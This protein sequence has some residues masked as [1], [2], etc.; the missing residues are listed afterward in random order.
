[1]LHQ[2]SDLYRWSELAQVLHQSLWLEIVCIGCETFF[3]FNWPMDK[4]EQL[5]SKINLDLPQ[6]DVLHVPLTYHTPTIG[7]R[8]SYSIGIILEVIKYFWIDNR[9]LDRHPQNVQHSI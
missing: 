9:F 6:V 4:K 5:P 3:Q 1:M 7:R 2:G 8:Q